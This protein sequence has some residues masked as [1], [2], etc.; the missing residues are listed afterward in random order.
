M[1]EAVGGEA[2]AVDLLVHARRRDAEA[3]GDGFGRE[4]GVVVR[5]VG[6]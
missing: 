5:I 1:A 3:V 4:G 2:A 6:H